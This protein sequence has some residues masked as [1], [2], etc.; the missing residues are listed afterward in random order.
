M[1]LHLLIIRQDACLKGTK[2]T[3]DSDNVYITRFLPDVFRCYQFFVSEYRS[4]LIFAL[5]SLLSYLLLVFLA[6]CCPEAVEEISHNHF[7]IYLS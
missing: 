1:P 4:I 5:T 6:Y 2:I 7:K 3:L